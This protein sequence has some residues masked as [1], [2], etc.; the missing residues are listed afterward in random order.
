M[1]SAPARP[2]AIVVDIAWENQTG[3]GSEDSLVAV[4]VNI[5]ALALDRC[6][7]SGTL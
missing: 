5:D 1:R 4:N 6:S 2:K 3:F 7:I